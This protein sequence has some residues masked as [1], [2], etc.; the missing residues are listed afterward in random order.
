MQLQHIDSDPR[1]ISI[2]QFRKDIDIFEKVLKK[3]GE[4]T[5]LKGNKVFFKALNPDFETKRQARIKK[6]TQEIKKLAKEISAKHP[7]RQGEISGSEWIIRERDR[8][9]TPKYYEEHNR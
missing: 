8:M 4:A 5:V 9:M 2:T 7:R 6:A 1:I 3:Y